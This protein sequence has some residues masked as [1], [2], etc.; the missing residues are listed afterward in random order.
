MSVEFVDIP[1]VWYGLSDDVTKRR[2]PLAILDRRVQD[3][4]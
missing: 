3:L 4:A 2:Q 1:V